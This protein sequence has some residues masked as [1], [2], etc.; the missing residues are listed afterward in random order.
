MENVALSPVA[1]NDVEEELAERIASLGQN[2]FYDRQLHPLNLASSWIKKAFVGDGDFS[3]YECAGLSCSRPLGKRAYPEPRTREE[4]TGLYGVSAG[5]CCLNCV[6]R[7]ILYRSSEFG[8]NQSLSLFNQMCRE[9]YGIDSSTI[10]PTPEKLQQTKC[11]GNIDIDWWHEHR[12]STPANIIDPP[13]IHS[14]MAIECAVVKR[15]VPV[16]MVNQIGVP[17]TSALSAVAGMPITAP[18]P[19]KSSDGISSEGPSTVAAPFFINTDPKLLS[20]TSMQNNSTDESKASD[21]KVSFIPAAENEVKTHTFDASI[22]FQSKEPIHSKNK[23]VSQPKKGKRG[24]PRK[25]PLTEKP[26]A[27]ENTPAKNP[28]VMMLG[29]KPARAYKKR[30]NAVAKE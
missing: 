1:P 18:A 15:A 11:G 22:I 16:I 14:R 7:R 3:M 25:K 9:V 29:E 24:R 30:K 8:F 13:F 12:S 27:S 6:Y 23:I 5:Y 28:E 2:P 10:V 21:V 20:L 4:N 26:E 19:I 17:K